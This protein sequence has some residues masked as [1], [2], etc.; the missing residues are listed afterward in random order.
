MNETKYTKDGKKVVVLGK[1]NSEEYIVQE[2]FVSAGQEIPGGEN[3]VTKGLL[4]AP[5]ESW[6]DKS[7]REKE[8]SYN[9]RIKELERDYKK[10]ANLLIANK[11]KASLLSSALFEFANGTNHEEEIKTLRAF[12]SGEITHFF[13]DDHNPRIAAWNDDKMFV[14]DIYYNQRKIESMRLVSLYGSS[15]GALNY[16]LNCW[17]DGSETNTNVFPFTSYDAALAHAQSTCDQEANDFV[18]GDSRY[19]RLDK[20]AK[21]DGIKIPQAAQEKYESMAAASVAEKIAKLKNEIAQL[22]AANA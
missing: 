19:F 20:W 17:G 7:L 18:S 11:S 9:L 8:E 2:I 5:A 22:E 21:I 16:K 3:F 10:I 4:D 12:L 13:M 6:K 15:K 1:L 14:T